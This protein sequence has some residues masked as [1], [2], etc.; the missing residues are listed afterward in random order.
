[1]PPDD[2]VRLYDD[3]GI[4][5][6][7]PNAMQQDPEMAVARRKRWTRSLLLEYGELLSQRGVLDREM[8][9]AMEAGDERAKQREESASHARRLGQ[10]DDTGKS[11]FLRDISMFGVV[12]SHRVEGSDSILW[13]LKSAPEDVDAAIPARDTLSIGDFPAAPLTANVIWTPQERSEELPA[14]A[15]AQPEGPASDEW[16]KLTFSEILEYNFHRNSRLLA[17][18]S[19]VALSVTTAHQNPSRQVKK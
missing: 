12:A 6:F 5:P 19:A 1:M 13:K 10:S 11:Q 15:V 8:H 17:F 9:P 4:A 16:I 3:E 2:R 14:F 7:R 18:V